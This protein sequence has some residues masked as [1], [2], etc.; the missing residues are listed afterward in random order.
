MKIPCQACHQLTP[1]LLLPVPS[2][3]E[4][5]LSS[6]GLLIIP[7]TEVISPWGFWK[8]LLCD[9]IMCLS[10]VGLVHF[11]HEILHTCNCLFFYMIGRWLSRLGAEGKEEKVALESAW[12]FQEI[13]RLDLLNTCEMVSDIV[14]QMEKWNFGRMIV[15]YLLRKMDGYDLRCHVYEWVL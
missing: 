9:K 11:I 2:F 10:V 8:K 4:K 12:R 6:Y 7:N 15:F 14:F 5:E 1:G 13:A 3:S